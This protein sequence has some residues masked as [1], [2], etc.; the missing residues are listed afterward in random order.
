MGPPLLASSHHHLGPFLFLHPSPSHFFRPSRKYLG[1]KAYLTQ[2]PK[3]DFETLCTFLEEL[4]PTL[5]VVQ[6]LNE[7]N[8]R[9]LLKTHTKFIVPPVS[10][11]QGRQGRGCCSQVRGTP[12]WVVVLGLIG[13]VIRQVESAGCLTVVAGETALIVSLCPLLA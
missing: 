2:S 10:G 3:P 11:R 6:H 1:L 5:Q 9:C 12:C 13:D 7:Y 4:T 8:V